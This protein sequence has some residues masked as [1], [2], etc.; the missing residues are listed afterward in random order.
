LLKEKAVENAKIAYRLQHPDFS[1]AELAK[2]TST[3][4]HRWFPRARDK[5]FG[6]RK[7]PMDREYL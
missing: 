2:I 7:I 1:R 4:K 3:C 6:Y 5:K